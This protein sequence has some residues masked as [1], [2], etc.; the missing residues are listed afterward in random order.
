MRVNKPYTN[1]EYASLAVYCNRNNCHIEDK[2]D[3]LESVENKVYAPN[4]KEKRAAEYPDIAD[5]LD[6][7]YWDMVNSTQNWREK[8]AEIKAKYPKE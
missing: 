7:I 2:G 4:Y 5:Q 3:Y 1:K 6:M 8:I